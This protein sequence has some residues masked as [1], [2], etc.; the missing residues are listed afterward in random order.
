MT[1][2]LVVFPPDV[3]PTPDNLVLPSVEEHKYS[4][5]DDDAKVCRIIT[6]DELN[7]SYV[8]SNIRAFQLQD[9]NILTLDVDNQF[10]T[11]TYDHSV[12]T[13]LLLGSIDYGRGVKAEQY[14]MTN[15]I[16]YPIDSG[17]QL[18]LNL[19]NTP[20]LV[21]IRTW[22]YNEAKRLNDQRLQMAEIVHDFTEAIGGLGHA[23]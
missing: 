2:R 1:V 14:G 6:E 16:I 4:L 11:L 22:Y 18:L 21:A 7:A 3:L 19:T 15:G 23:A 8:D 12:Q 5:V 17:G 10:V 9:V 20:N 13:S